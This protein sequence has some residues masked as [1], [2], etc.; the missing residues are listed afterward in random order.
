M[1]SEKKDVDRATNQV[2][3]SFNRFTAIGFLIRAFSPLP[4]S[5]ERL[6]AALGQSFR[7]NTRDF[8]KPLSER[9]GTGS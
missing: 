7:Q 2:E 3:N 8:S 1:R 5:V 4:S 9:H 6:V